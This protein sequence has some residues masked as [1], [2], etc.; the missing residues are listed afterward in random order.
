MAVN[1]TR[2][3]EFFKQILTSDEKVTLEGAISRSEQAFKSA[4]LKEHNQFWEARDFE[5]PSSTR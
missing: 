1:S 3:Q 2:G 5:G 4:N